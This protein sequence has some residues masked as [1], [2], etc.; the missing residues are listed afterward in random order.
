MFLEPRIYFLVRGDYRNLKWLKFNFVGIVRQETIKAEGVNPPY[1]P[2]H[3]IPLT[4]FLDM[5]PCSL[6]K[7]L[8]SYEDP[9]P[10]V[11]NVT[12]CVS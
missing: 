9:L 3:H 1:R 10:H 7:Q 11:Y 4:L 12:T 5:V 6:V 2:F 8:G